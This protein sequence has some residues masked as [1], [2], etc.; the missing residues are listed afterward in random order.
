MPDDYND[1]PG[2]AQGPPDGAP[3]PAFRAFDEFADIGALI[4]ASTS[5]VG[6]LPIIWAADD[7]PM[8]FDGPSPLDED[9]A[10]KPNDTI[11]PLTA[12]DVPFIN[13]LDDDEPEEE[14]KPKARRKRKPGPPPETEAQPDPEPE[15]VVVEIVAER[16]ARAPVGSYH[17]PF[18]GKN[19]AAMTSAFASCGFEFRFNTRSLG[20]EY[21]TDGKWTRLDDRYAASARETIGARFF[22]KTERGPRALHFGRE[23]W[24]LVLDA[25]LQDRQCDPFQ[26]WL[27]TLPS[28]DGTGRLNTYLADLF[29][30]QGGDLET[31]VARFLFLAAVQRTFE[32]ACLLR[33]MPVLIGGQNIGKSALTRAILPPGIPGLHSD[34]LRWDAQAAQQVDATRGRVIVEVSEMAGRSRAEIGNIKAFIARIDDGSVRLPWRRNPD[35][36]PRRFVLIGTTNRADD[37]PNDPAGLSRF[38]PIQLEH[39]SHVEAYMDLHRVQLWAEAVHRYR[40]GMRA[41]LPRDLMPEQA[42]RA[43]EHRS[44]DEFLEDAIATKITLT[45]MTIGEIKTQL[46]DGFR[47]HSAHR[48]GNGL[49]NAAW[50]KKKAEVDGKRRWIWSPPPEMAN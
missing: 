5:H 34:G 29:G 17:D 35:P 42:A 3:P 20:I 28:W 21:L 32:P 44:R 49:R 45:E 24:S 25:Y 27:E 46:G 16:E 43:E 19:L 38:V 9:N 36:L 8:Y 48:I 13:S 30:C 41:N 15:P 22:I 1:D 14:P 50:V 12:D 11:P 33:E 4:E 23:R 47:D 26:V 39:G 7:E 31:W 18:P 37:L 6:P 40:E 10:M 2:S